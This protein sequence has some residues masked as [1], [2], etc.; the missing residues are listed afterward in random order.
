MCIIIATKRNVTGVPNESRHNN[1]GFWQ[2]GGK[3]KLCG[4]RGTNS[5]VENVYCAVFTVQFQQK[6]I[7]FELGEWYVYFEQWS[8]HNQRFVSIVQPR[9]FTKSCTESL[10]SNGM[11]SSNYGLFL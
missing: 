6:K 3:L 10:P 4:I 5:A 9:V 7:L 11:I 8:L 2:D 1:Q